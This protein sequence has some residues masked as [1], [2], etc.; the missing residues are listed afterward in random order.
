[1]AETLRRIDVGATTGPRGD[2]RPTFPNGRYYLGAADWER[3]APASLPESPFQQIVGRLRELDRLVLVPGERG[4]APGVTLLPTP[5]ETPGH[6][7]VRIASNGE[8]AY[9]VGDLV[10]HVVELRH[11]EWTP[12][13]R[14][15]ATLVPSR[16]QLYE[17]A[18]RE[19]GLVI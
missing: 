12:R 14:D 15:A 10:H 3:F 13:L 17:R 1:M 18:A 5:G 9:Y 2:Q 11:P 8:T 16:R 7:S 19:G 4:I 6:L